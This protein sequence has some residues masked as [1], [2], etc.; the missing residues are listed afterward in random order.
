MITTVIV[1]KYLKYW[2][3]AFA[4]LAVALAKRAGMTDPGRLGLSKARLYS[5][6]TNFRHS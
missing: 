6:P 2:I 5:Q 4:R 1:M 3:P